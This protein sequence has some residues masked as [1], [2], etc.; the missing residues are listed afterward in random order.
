LY[1]SLLGV[2]RETQV[3]VKI[4]LSPH[5]PVYF[6]DCV[7]QVREDDQ[8][9]NIPPVANKARTV[10]CGE[11]VARADGEAVIEALEPSCHELS[12]WLVE[13]G[14]VGRKN[15][16]TLGRKAQAAMDIAWFDIM[17]LVPSR[18]RIYREIMNIKISSELTR[19]LRFRL[20]ETLGFLT[21]VPA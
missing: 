16:H 20:G 12:W 8:H 6:V 3:R 21:F 5:I 19:S 18:C 9:I 7:R 13:D 1:T 10:G 14:R 11:W 4:P 2:K 17:G 15:R